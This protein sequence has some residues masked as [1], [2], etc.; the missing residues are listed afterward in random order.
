MG[1]TI[2]SWNVEAF[3]GSTKRLESMAAWLGYAHPEEKPVDLFGIM[4]VEGVDL[5]TLARD[6][7]PDYDFHLTDGRQNK[8]ILVGVRRGAFEQFTITQK[9]E[10]KGA[11]EHMR[12]GSL[13][14]VRPHGDDDFTHILFLHTAAMSDS[15]GFGA[16][17]EMFEKVAK[18]KRGL[19]KMKQERDGAKE[20]EARFI[21]LG[22]LNTA[23]LRYPRDRKSDQRVTSEAEI[24]SLES[25][26]RLTL[27]PK[28]TD[29]TWTGSRGEA[30]LDHVLTSGPV[31]LRAFGGRPDNT[32]Y[33]V[34][35]RGWPELAGKSRT[36]FVDELSDHALLLVEM[37]DSDEADRP[38]RSNGRAPRK[39]FFSRIFG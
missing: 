11:N 39:G 20:G 19:D 36:A 34:A 13:V 5:D 15:T 9:R 2:A 3:R 37:L 25:L 16:R 28:S 21:V 23:G 38:A 33:T 26:T 24:D 14:S 17:T 29:H 4:E 12:P 22:D 18:M 8:E 35:V 30:D 27:M 10:F 7:F 1:T 32:P 6:H 31:R